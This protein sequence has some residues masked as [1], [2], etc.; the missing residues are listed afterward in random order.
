LEWFL[1]GGAHDG[2]F[3]DRDLLASAVIEGR[4]ARYFV[5]KTSHLP[6]MARRA[7]FLFAFGINGIKMSIEHAVSCCTV[8]SIRGYGAYPD[9][10]LIH[11]N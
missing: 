5:F 9:G 8:T 6:R 11:D 7:I 3:M 2:R 1:H 4:V 10:I